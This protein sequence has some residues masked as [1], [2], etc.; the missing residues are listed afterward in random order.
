MWFVS[1]SGVKKL[2]S[3]EKKIQVSWFSEHHRKK[4]I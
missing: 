2:T 4:M 1:K 3:E